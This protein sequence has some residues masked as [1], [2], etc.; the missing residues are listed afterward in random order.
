MQFN[1]KNALLL[2]ICIL[3]ASFAGTSYAGEKSGPTKGN[4][5][6]RGVDGRDTGQNVRIRDR[7]NASPKDPAKALVKMQR[8]S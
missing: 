8:S 5:G 2:A 7:S 1:R 6:E 3:V 4:G